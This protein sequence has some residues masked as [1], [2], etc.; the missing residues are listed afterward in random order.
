DM[1]LEALAACAGVTLLAV[2]TAMD[3]RIEDGFVRAEGDLDF[4]GTLAVDRNVPVGFKA[5]RLRFDL[6]TEADNKEMATLMRLT[7][8]Y[9]VVHQTLSHGPDLS[10]GYERKESARS[11][12]GQR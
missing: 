7:E 1:V 4:S 2:A 5:V 9:C 8:R 10:I 6:D 3:I 11:K 12:M